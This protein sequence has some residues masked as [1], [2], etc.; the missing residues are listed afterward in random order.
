MTAVRQR[1]PLSPS[2]RHMRKRSFG[3]DTPSTRPGSNFPPKQAREE[4]G[5]STQPPA[6]TLSAQT[7][8]SKPKLRP[9]EA[10]LGQKR[11]VALTIVI[12]VSLTIPL[13]VLTLI[14]SG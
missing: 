2:P 4:T 9:R 1:A 10:T 11:L 6:A 3:R 7:R 14:F 13:L 12:L 8:T 5:F